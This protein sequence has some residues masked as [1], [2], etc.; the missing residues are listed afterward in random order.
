MRVLFL[1]VF[2]ILLIAGSNPKSATAVR[3]PKAPTIDGKLNEPEWQLAKPETDF[4]QLEPIEGA[5][6]TSER[7]SGSCMMTKHCM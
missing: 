1:V 6:P 7:K 5:P 2:P 4:V 3:T